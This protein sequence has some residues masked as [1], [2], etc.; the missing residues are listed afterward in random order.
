M[1]DIDEQVR[2]VWLAAQDPTVVARLEAIYAQVSEQIAARGPACWASGRCCNFAKAGHDLF[3]TLLE[4]A[5]CVQRAQVPAASSPNA[6][7]TSRGVALPQ[8]TRVQHTHIAAAREHGDC[9][10]LQANLCAGGAHAVKPL[11]CRVYFCDQTAQQ[12]QHELTERSL[13]QL[14]QLHADCNIPY[15]YDEWRRQLTRCAEIAS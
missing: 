5:Y 13:T 9:P 1:H 3:V 2:A 8:L 11:G 10:Y 7:D 12:W 4:A 14:R 6:N 15:L